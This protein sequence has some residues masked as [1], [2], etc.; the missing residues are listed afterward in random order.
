ME[1]L[2]S[3]EPLPDGSRRKRRRQSTS[4]RSEPPRELGRMRP[5]YDAGSSS[6]VGS[7]S[8]IH[9]VR[10]VRLALARNGAREQQVAESEEELVPG[11]DDQ[12]RGQS[13][14][15]SLWRED[16]VCLDN[17]SALSSD[18]LDVEFED[19]VRWSR[20][21]FES[22]HP[23]F[24]FLHAPT[25]LEILEKV[26]SQGF[27]K[28]RPTE[29]IIVR[30]IMSI[31]LADRRQ[32]PKVPGR[33]LPSRLA[34]RTID[35][36]LSVLQPLIIQSDSL[37][38][39]QAVVSIQV[40]LISMLRLNAASRLGGLIV[41]TLFHLGLHRCPARFSQFAASDADIRRRVFWAVYCLERYL[42][43][44][45]GLPLDIKDDDLD[46]CYP[47]HELHISLTRNCRESTG[48][49]HSG[50]NYFLPILFYINMLKFT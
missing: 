46:V 45:L 17:D 16:E 37:F 22:W 42:S 2:S 11:E 27:S 24:P 43:Q 3:Y 33:L 34:F 10:T 47:G 40:F 13:T 29:K 25:V 49:V 36:A 19:L 38:G 6:F 21:Y 50:K 7:G 32:L 9:F 41:R 15:S 14:P 26:S 23:P 39:L 18:D 4:A 44:S 1:D 5:S 31:S 8:G 48:E 12:L 35:E 28:I 30:S 20:P